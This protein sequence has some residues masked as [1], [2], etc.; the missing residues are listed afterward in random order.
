MSKSKF[1]EISKDVD[2]F[3]KE[4]QINQLMNDCKHEVMDI[5]K[6]NQNVEAVNKVN[7]KMLS[8]FSKI[9]YTILD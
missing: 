7:D 4:Q 2:K 1:N 9:A 3:N 8:T 5:F 6:K